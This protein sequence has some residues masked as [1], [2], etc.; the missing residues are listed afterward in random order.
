MELKVDE[1]DEHEGNGA[2]EEERNEGHGD[3]EDG[4]A[5]VGLVG[6]AKAHIVELC[7]EE[8]RHGYC[9]N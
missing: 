6:A 2:G 9:L 5:A 4:V 1:S 8:E 7:E 3:V